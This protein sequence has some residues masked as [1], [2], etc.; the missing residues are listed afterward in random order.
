[1]CSGDLQGFQVTDQ[2]VK[3]KENGKKE[4]VRKQKL[5]ILSLTVPLQKQGRGRESGRER[6]GVLEQGKKAGLSFIET[7]D[8]S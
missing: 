6:E 5:R 8:A 1:M 2:N 3:R 4:T 7:I